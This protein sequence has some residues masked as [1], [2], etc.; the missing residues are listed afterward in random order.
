MT[1]NEASAIYDY[2]NSDVNFSSR[3]NTFGFLDVPEGSPVPRVSYKV[4]SSPTFWETDDQWQRWRFFVVAEDKFDCLEIADIIE[5]LL[6]RAYGTIGGI[7]FDFISR[8]DA[9]EVEQRDDEL[10]ELYIDYR[11]KWH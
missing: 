1:I 5:G 9:S 6:N 11:V 8:L 2:L 3:V 4:I 10:Y 7:Y